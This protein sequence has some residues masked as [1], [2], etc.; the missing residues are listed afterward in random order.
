MTITTAQ[1]A[2]YYEILALTKLNIEEAEDI[3]WA[4]KNVL[5]LNPE[6][7]Y[8]DTQGKLI[9]LFRRT[10]KVYLV[11]IPG[12]E[13]ISINVHTYST[14]MLHFIR[15]SIKHPC[16][17]AARNCR[18]FRSALAAFSAAFRTALVPSVSYSHTEG[19]T[20]F[21]LQMTPLAGL[22]MTTSL[23]EF[24]KVIEHITE[25]HLAYQIEEAKLFLVDLELLQ[26]AKMVF[27]VSRTASLL[28]TL[29]PIVNNSY[30]KI[31]ETNKEGE[32]SHDN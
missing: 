22:S 20:Y 7:S 23:Y 24:I 1:G 8:E 4:K 6:E 32:L 19:A 3:K 26:S 9:K 11:K 13:S 27:P 31:E 12:I 10:A 21:R 29:T 14:R 16:F 15:V 18:Y 2:L 25:L 30:P 17:I 5:L 28:A